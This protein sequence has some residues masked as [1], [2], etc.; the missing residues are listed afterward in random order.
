MV[1]TVSLHFRF[2]FRSPT[3]LILIVWLAI[4]SNAPDGT[5]MI[6]HVFL[7]RQVG[8]GQKDQD[9]RVVTDQSC[10]VNN[11]KNQWTH[12]RLYGHYLYIRFLTVGKKI[13]VLVLL[14][15]LLVW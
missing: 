12:R 3:D 5:E 9:T 6:R 4:Q 15:L 1:D 14:L 8:T 2:R 10:Y 7:R 11:L 13:V